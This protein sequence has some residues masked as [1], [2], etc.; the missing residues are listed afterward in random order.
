MQ[1][2]CMQM[3][4]FEGAFHVFR[5]CRNRNPW[6]LCPTRVGKLPDDNMIISNIFSRM[7]LRKKQNLPFFPA[8]IRMTC[9]IKCSIQ[10]C[11]HPPAAA[12][13][14]IYASQPAVTV[15]AATCIAWRIAWPADI[16]VKETSNQC[17]RIAAKGEIWDF[18]ACLLWWFERDF[19]LYCT[20]WA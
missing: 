10:K 7:S 20:D 17:S 1:I 2:D 8:N 19:R 6:K 14:R 13:P 5:P 9:R 12:E 3:V 18:E 4:I 15:A 11:E 16:H